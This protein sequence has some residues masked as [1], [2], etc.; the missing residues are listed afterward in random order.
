MKKV[1]KILLYLFF[2]I[3]F[4]VSIAGVISRDTIKIPGDYEGKYI[5]ISGVKI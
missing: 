4:I 1:L 5:E 2:A 3:I